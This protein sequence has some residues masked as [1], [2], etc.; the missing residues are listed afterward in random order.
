MRVARGSTEQLW[1]HPA[2]M[3]SALGEE[4][5]HATLTVRADSEVLRLLLPGAGEVAVCNCGIRHIGDLVL[6]PLS[7]LR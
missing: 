5:R 2:D 1:A 7:L 6:L 3:R 4:G